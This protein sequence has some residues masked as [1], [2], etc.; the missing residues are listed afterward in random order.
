MENNNSCIENSLA[1]LWLINTITISCTNRGSREPFAVIAGSS[2]TYSSLAVAG[3]VSTQP[4][5]TGNNS[6]QVYSRPFS[7]KQYRTNCYPTERSFDSSYK[8]LVWA[9]GY[10]T[11]KLMIP[12]WLTKM[13]ISKCSRYGLTT[14]TSTEFTKCRL[15]WQLAGTQPAPAVSC[16]CD[17]L[18][19]P[20]KTSLQR[21]SSSTLS[22]ECSFLNQ[23]VAVFWLLRTN[24]YKNLIKNLRN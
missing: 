20:Q 9:N 8:T 3:M 5:T 2:V 24:V 4:P 22:E 6:G 17:K 16:F 13:T 23:L 12:I 18:S 7:Q 14:K 10:R 19:T 11:I 1:D 21:P 15:S